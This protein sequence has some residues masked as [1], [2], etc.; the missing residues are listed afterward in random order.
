MRVTALLPS[1]P[2]ITYITG[3][4]LVITD[5]NG[6]DHSIVVITNEPHNLETACPVGLYRCLADGSLTI[7]LDGGEA[8]WAPWTVSLAPGI[9]ITV[10]NTPGECRSFGFEK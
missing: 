1:L 4:S 5:N 8:L 2:V 10:V 6:F 9:E 7:L 3:F